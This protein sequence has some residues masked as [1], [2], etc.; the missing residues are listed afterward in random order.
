MSKHGGS[1][2]ARLERRMTRCQLFSEVGGCR[3]ALRLHDTGKRIRRGRELW[4]W[5]GERT[6]RSEGKAGVGSKIV[7]RAG[8]GDWPLAA[9]ISTAPQTLLVLTFLYKRLPFF[10]IY[11]A[12]D[13]S[14]Q[15]TLNESDINT[16]TA[17]VLPS[18]AVV[19]SVCLAPHSR[20]NTTAG[21]LRSQR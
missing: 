4:W 16:W 5:L 21:F 14:F 3:S 7:R 18:S 13:L 15:A 12:S 17:S 11:N 2:F 1:R 20:S 6:G 9:D 19:S 10:G 8:D